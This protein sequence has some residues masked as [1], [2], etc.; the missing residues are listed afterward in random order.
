MYPETLELMGDK[1]ASLATLRLEF[2]LTDQFFDP[3]LVEALD[4]LSPRLAAIP[5]L[6]N[7]IIQIQDCS[8][9]GEFREGSIEMLT[10]R[11]WIAEIIRAEL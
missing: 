3:Y 1:C 7:V 8:G 10:D 11:G 5:S 9:E 6:D 4:F 2:C